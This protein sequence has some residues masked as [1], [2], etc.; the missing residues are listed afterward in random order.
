MPQKIFVIPSG[1]SIDKHFETYPAEKKKE[2]RRAMGI[3]E[4]AFVLI[5]LGRL[6]K[7]KNTDELLVGISWVIDENPDTVLLIVGHG[8]ERKDLER[9]V[10]H[11]D[12]E[13]NV[14]FTG[15]V[16]PEDV[17]SYYQ[18]SDVFVS[19]ST[20][21]TQGLVYIEAAANGLPLICHRDSC[22][23]GI[24]D[25]NVNG[26]CYESM[27]EFKKAFVKCLRDS[28]FRERASLISRK[29]AMKF[30]KQQF[31]DRIERVYYSLLP[32]KKKPPLN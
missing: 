21:E 19:A 6:G 1:I 11:L 18:I 4:D 23:I 29:N 27:D 20:S 22:L 24:I 26:F 28:E 3:S 32:Q 17:H 2:L 8:P 31:S 9:W 16:P 13:K 15:A 5:S 14:I 10:R 25:E 12:L 7:E 30:S